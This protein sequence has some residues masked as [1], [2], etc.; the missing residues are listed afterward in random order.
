MRLF[1]VH[2]HECDP[3]KC[4]GER[5]LKQHLVEELDVPPRGAILLDPFAPMALVPQDA[6][7]A[8]GVIDCSWNKLSKPFQWENR[9]ALPYLVPA[10]PVNFGKP[11]KLSSAEALA[12]AAH[13]LGEPETAAKL[14]APFKWGKTFLAL[15]HEILE[16]YRAARSRE[17]VLKIQA[18]LLSQLKG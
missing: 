4:T 16:G 15:N 10:N 7:P 11:T 9:R 2:K 12:A 3:A 8:I 5:L 13:I 18:E 1:L 17:E 6:P 14:L